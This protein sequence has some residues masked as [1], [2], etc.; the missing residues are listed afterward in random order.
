MQGLGIYLGMELLSHTY[1]NLGLTFGGSVQLFSKVATLPSLSQPTCMVSW[2][3]A[4]KRRLSLGLYVALYDMQA[5]GSRQLQHCGP[6]VGH[7]WRNG[8]GKFSQWAKL[9][10]VLL[11][12]QSPWN[13]KWGNMQSYHDSW[14]EA[15][16]KLWDSKGMLI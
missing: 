14:A 8:E 13:E 6:A 3:W 2:A 7:L 4:E 5:P 10:G 9:R 15:K 12:V 1:N 11:D 16:E